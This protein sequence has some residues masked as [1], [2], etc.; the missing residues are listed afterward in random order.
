FIARASEAMGQPI[1]ILSGEKPLGPPESITIMRDEKGIPSAA[2]AHS[3]RTFS[4][5]VLNVGSP[6]KSG[7][8]VNLI[9]AEK[10]GSRLKTYHVQLVIS[11]DRN[12]ATLKLLAQR[13]PATEV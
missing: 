4:F 8:S 13:N 3:G 10:V 2:I 7:S 1:E 11:D 5:S 6:F 12:S 9:G